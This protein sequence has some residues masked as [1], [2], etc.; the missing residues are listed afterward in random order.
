MFFY[1]KQPHNSRIITRF[2]MR[3]CFK[4]IR[5]GVSIAYLSHLNA[6]DD[7]L[8]I[9]H[10]TAPAHVKYKNKIARLTQHHFSFSCSPPLSCQKGQLSH[11][12]KI[13]STTQSII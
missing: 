12:I 2:L 1:C 8:S 11:K 4:N 7:S 3:L 10:L 6:Q 5:A 9:A 13:F